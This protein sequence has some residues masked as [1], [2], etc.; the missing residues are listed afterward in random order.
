MGLVLFDLFIIDVELGVICK[1]AKPSDD[2]K[3]FR[4]VK[5]KGIERTSKEFFQTTGV[6]IKMANAIQCKQV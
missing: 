3:L 5:R 2:T 1:V 6:S 4:V